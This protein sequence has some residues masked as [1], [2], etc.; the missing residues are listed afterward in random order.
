MSCGIWKW[1][2]LGIC[3]TILVNMDITDREKEILFDADFLRHKASLSSKIQSALQIT[4]KELITELKNI[5]Q[6]HLFWNYR[7][8]SPKVS[9]GENY[10]SLP[11]FM[12]DYPR[13]FK[14]DEVV[15]VRNMILWGSFLSTTFQ[16]SGSIIENVKPKILNSI[17]KLKDPDNWFVCVNNSP[18]EYHYELNNYV[19]ISTLS[20]QQF[21]K[22]IDDH[23]F[24]KL[25]KRH[26]LKVIPHLSEVIKGNFQEIISLLN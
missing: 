11:Y 9:R 24:I 17:E 15:A 16:V 5:N 21:T 26:D 1:I 13:C 18:W 8:P 2:Y 20:D 23:P 7:Q 12:L 14:K 10:Q 3:I 4:G 25:S 22:I 19:Q 6:N